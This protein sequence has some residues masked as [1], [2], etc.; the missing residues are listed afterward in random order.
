MKLIDN[1][2]I[3]ILLRLVANCLG[4]SCKVQ[5]IRLGQTVMRRTLMLKPY[6]VVTMIE[7]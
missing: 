1:P 5:G 3:S 7:L 6:L 4:Y 2:S